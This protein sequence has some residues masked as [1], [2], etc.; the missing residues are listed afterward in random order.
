MQ[1][2]GEKINKITYRSSEVDRRDGLEI[3]E[4]GSGGPEI[5]SQILGGGERGRL[6]QSVLW[7]LLSTGKRRAKSDKVIRNGREE[8]SIYLSD[9]MESSCSSSS[10]VRFIMASRVSGDQARQTSQFPPS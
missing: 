7:D 1:K 8:V 6:R 10:T 3:I 5:G 4:S 2:S 9:I